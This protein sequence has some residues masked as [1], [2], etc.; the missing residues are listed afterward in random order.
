MIVT[1][2]L[3]DFVLSVTEVAVIVT[4][5]PLGATDGAE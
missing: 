4:L 2:E 5:P 3:A 1:V